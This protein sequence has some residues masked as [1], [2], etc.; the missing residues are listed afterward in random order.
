[1]SGRASISDRG[2]TWCSMDGRRF[3]DILS[4]TWGIQTHYM[5]FDLKSS[6]SIKRVACTPQTISR[7]FLIVVPHTIDPSAHG[8]A[9]HE[10]G[11]I[12]LQQFGRRAHIV[13]AGVEPKLVAVWIENH[14]HPVVDRRRYSAGRRS[15]AIV[16]ESAIQRDANI[17]SAKEQVRRIC[18]GMK[19]TRF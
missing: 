7:A 1:M 11:I 14:C 16:Y 8:I 2:K 9:P 5:I 12:G 13:H 4:I 18:S 10:P 3:M 6:S 17:V 15:E 19:S